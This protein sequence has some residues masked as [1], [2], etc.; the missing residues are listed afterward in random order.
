[1][2]L[3]QCSPLHAG[4]GV[5]RIAIGAV[6]I[7]HG[8]IKVLAMSQ[9]VGFM[10]G[11]GIPSFLAYCVIIGEVVGGFLLVVG[12]FERYAAG[13]L[14]AIMV[15]AMFLVTKP[16]FPEYEFVLLLVLLGLIISGAGQYRIL[17]KCGMCNCCKEKA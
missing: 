13:V 10:G 12:F 5:I 14:A 6:F 7:Y 8:I 15:G 2:K 11:L 3:S 1:M 4:L 17:C 16:S 9:V